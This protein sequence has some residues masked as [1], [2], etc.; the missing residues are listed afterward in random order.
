MKGKFLTPIVVV[1]V[2]GA[3]VA[4]NQFEPQRTTQEQYDAQMEAQ[5]ELDEIAELEVDSTPI[6]TSE[7]ILEYAVEKADEIMKD[8]EATGGDYSVRVECSNGNFTIEV[9]SALAP[10]GAAQFKRAI[11]DGVYDE[12]RFFRVV[13]GF[14]VQFGI[15]GDPEKSSVWRE[16]KI[17]DDP[18]KTGNTRGT[19]CFATSGANSRT[20]QVFISYG[21]NSNLDGMGFAPFGRVVEG[22][23]VVDAI[24]SR[25]GQNPDQGAIQSKGNVYLNSAYPNLDYIKKVV[26]LGEGD[27]AE[28]AET[29][30]SEGDAGES[31]DAAA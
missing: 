25:D 24:Y 3:I 19:I 26:I 10:L 15:S 9:E 21:D 5:R 17:E 1:V 23:D 13:P 18:V 6:L 11:M 31:E 14:V 20:T 27:D 12:A 22:M 7:Q 4:I 8:R 2:V 29:E 28:D 30:S 16:K